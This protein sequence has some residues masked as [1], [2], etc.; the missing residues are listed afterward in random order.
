MVAQQLESIMLV[1]AN[2]LPALSEN[3]EHFAKM[4][5]VAN[6]LMTEQNL[7]DMDGNQLAKLSPLAARAMADITTAAGNTDANDG[8]DIFERMS[9]MMFGDSE[10]IIPLPQLDGMH[11]EL[12]A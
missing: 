4:G 8:S 11:K 2:T 9:D 5:A 7:A 6:Y 3:Q 1:L 12:G 10:V